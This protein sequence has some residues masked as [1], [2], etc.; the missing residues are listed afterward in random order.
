MGDVLNVLYIINNDF[1]VKANEIF[2]PRNNM[3]ISK[4]DGRFDNQTSHQRDTIV[5][6]GT[7]LRLGKQYETV[8]EFQRKKQ[9]IKI[10]NKMIQEN[11][12]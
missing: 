4:N 2:N 11:K 7:F 3:H 10:R 9:L 8:E 6:M 1:F 12:V 5:N